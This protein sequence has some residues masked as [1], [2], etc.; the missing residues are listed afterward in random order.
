[1][2][3]AAAAALAW[4]TRGV[5][6]AALLAL[7]ALLA[8]RIFLRNRAR[9]GAGDAGVY[10]VACV[11]CKFPQLAGQF[12]YHWLKACGKRGVV[13]EYKSPARCRAA[14]GGGTL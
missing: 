12:R 8:F 4:P 10:A 11:G 6:I 9:L 5:S 7:Y 14:A 13:V 1:L 3:P 2:L